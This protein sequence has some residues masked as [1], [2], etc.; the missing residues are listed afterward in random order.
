MLTHVFPFL[1]PARITTQ[2]SDHL[3][4]LAT[5]CAALGENTA[6]VTD[7]LRTA[8]VLDRY[9]PVITPLGL[10]LAGQVTHHPLLGSRRILTSQVWFADP[11]GHWVR[12]LSRFYRLGRP[13]GLDDGDPSQGRSPSATN[14]NGPDDWPEYGDCSGD[15]DR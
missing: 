14:G 2:V 8:P 9:A 12:T 11:E 1:D 5:D 15:A 13:A 6:F 3:R 7:R 4:S 10:R